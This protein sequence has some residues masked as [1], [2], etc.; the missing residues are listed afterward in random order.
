MA[1]YYRREKR[2]EMQVIRTTPP[3]ISVLLPLGRLPLSLEF[4]LA[5]CFWAVSPRRILAY[6]LDA[7]VG[8]KVAQAIVAAFGPAKEHHSKVDPEISTMTQDLWRVVP[9]RAQE[10]LRVLLDDTT[11]IDFEALQRATKQ[12]CSRAGL[13]FS[14]D[15]ASALRHELPDDIETSHTSSIPRKVL[16]QAL[17]DHGGAQDL[18]R[19]ALGGRVLGFLDSVLE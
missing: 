6:S 14:G 1:V 11:Q 3:S 18:I 16:S 4:Y 17:R 10:K 9:P 2:Y 19:F 8:G 7:S 13:L 15:L 5:R 12:E